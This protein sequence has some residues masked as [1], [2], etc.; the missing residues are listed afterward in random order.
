MNIAIIFAGGTGS[1]VGNTLP[2]QFL[3]VDGMPILIHTLNLFQNHPEIHKIYLAVPENFVSHS[4]HL[5][6]QYQITKL[7]GVVV[8]GETAQE[9]IYITLQKA[10]QENPGDS[11]VLLHDGVRPCVTP[12]VISGN[13]RAVREKGNAITCIP[14]TETIILSS[15]G[16]CV[17]DVTVR[18]QTFTAQAPQSFYLQ[19]ILFYHDRIR[20]T[21]T[22]Y[23]NMV[24]ACTILNTLGIKAHMVMGN[25]GNIKITTPEDIYFFRSMLHYNKSY[26][27]HDTDREGKG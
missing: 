7:S 8:G 20:A 16:A 1:R 18:K 2:K 26:H 9:S 12:S 14:G 21:Q 13:I 24:D 19:D 27:F 25:W 17:E 22:G 23:E 10:A 5:A 15:D 4:H 11:I 6:Q 3:D